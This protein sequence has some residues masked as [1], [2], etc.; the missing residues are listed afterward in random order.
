MLVDCTG[1]KC[2]AKVQNP[3]TKCGFCK[4][5]EAHKKGKKEPKPTAVTEC[6]QKSW[7]QFIIC[8]QFGELLSDIDYTLTFP[9]GV[10]PKQDK[11]ANGK[12]YKDGPK[13]IYKLDLKFVSNATWEVFPVD[14]GEK[15]KLRAFAPLHDDDSPATIKIFNV[16]DLAG[17]PLETLNGK[18]K[19]SSLEVEWTPTEEKLKD[20]TGGMIIFVARI[21][22]SMTM[23][24]PVQV[25]V[26]R[27]FE[28]VDEQNKPVDT[29]V[30]FHFSGGHQERVPSENGK[31]ELF[32]PLGES[33]L[34]AELP[35]LQGA[36][37]AFVA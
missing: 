19:E 25:R 37:L 5:K 21:D 18:I 26:K 16:H 14:I 15:I 8:N 20:V 9:E 2:G 3:E 23:S 35:K 4:A 7:V 13:G 30:I 34:G 12:V 29:D 31:F 24:P 11:L 36:H 33:L 17:D 1:H 10:N 27:Q 32:V 6:Q 22:K 28:L